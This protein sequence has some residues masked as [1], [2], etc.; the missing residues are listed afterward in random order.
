MTLTKEHIINAV[1]DHLG[2]PKSRSSEIVEH[3]LELIKGTL[4]AGEDVLLSGFGKF[5]VKDKKPRK[6]R[7]PATG[8]PLLLDSRRIVTFRC[9]PRLKDNINGESE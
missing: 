6:G 7:N 2:L 3:L 9:S 1:H 5:C 8:S 4:E